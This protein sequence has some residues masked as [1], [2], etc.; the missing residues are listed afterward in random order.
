MVENIMRS[1]KNMPT[2]TYGVSV[3]VINGKNPKDTTMAFPMM[4]L[5]GSPDIK[6]FVALM[7]LSSL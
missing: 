3:D 4:A 5:Y 7:S 6:L 1:A 2:V